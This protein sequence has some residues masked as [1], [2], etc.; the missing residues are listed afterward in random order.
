MANA[1]KGIELLQQVWLPIPWLIS[2]LRMGCSYNFLYVCSATLNTENVSFDAMLYAAAL[3]PALPYEGFGAKKANEASPWSGW[4]TL[5][6]VALFFNIAALALL[7]MVRYKH[8]GSLKSCD[9]CPH[10]SI[11]SELSSQSCGLTG[12][13]FFY[14]AQNYCPTPLA[15]ACGGNVPSPTPGVFLTSDPPH[16]AHCALRGCSIKFLPLQTVLYWLMVG[17]LALNTIGCLALLV[18]RSYLKSEEQT[19]APLSG[20]SLSDDNSN[21]VAANRSNVATDDD[22]TAAS[23]D[24]GGGNAGGDAGGD[25]SDNATNT[26][27]TA[28]LLDEQGMRFVAPAKLPRLKLVAT[29]S[30]ASHQLRLRANSRHH[31]AALNNV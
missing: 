30:A 16:L 7:V 25:A 26:T 4:D 1:S 14:N 3:L 18:M 21:N 17:T 11:P 22:N 10:E 27:A 15:A 8:I 13:D 28:R 5:M 29:R 2:L 19:P 31:A 24:S 23:A 20:T 9:K 12:E 6:L